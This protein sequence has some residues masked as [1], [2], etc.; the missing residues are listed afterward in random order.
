LPYQTA[1]IVC[2]P[3]VPPVLPLLSGHGATERCQHPEILTL[4]NQFYSKALETQKAIPPGHN[5]VMMYMG[6]DFAFKNAPM[7]YDWL[8]KLV[9]YAKRE[10]VMNVMYST[11]ERFLAAKKAAA[12]GAAG[13]SSGG[14]NGASSSSSNREGGISVMHSMPETTLAAD[15][16]AAGKTAGGAAVTDGSSG[17]GSCG[18]SSSGGSNVRWPLKDDDFLPYRCDQGKAWTGG[19]TRGAPGGGGGGMKVAVV[20]GV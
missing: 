1:Y 9:H 10:G 15:K 18:G 12:G 13:G 3:P 11:P 2:M 4:L 19:V 16:E 14:S 7:W 8:D 17:G 6:S 20:R 5:D